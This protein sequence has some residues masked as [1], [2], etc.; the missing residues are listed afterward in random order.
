ME[1]VGL[2]IVEN[3]ETI[4]GVKNFFERLMDAQEKLVEVGSFVERVN[5]VGNDLALFLHAAEIGDVEEADDDGFDAGIAEMVLAGDFEP[6]PGAVFALDAVVV[7]DPAARSDG[8]LVDALLG[9]A[10]LIGMENAD[11]GAAD[12]FAVEI[13]EDAAETFAGVKD[14][15]V[16]GEQ[17][18]EFARRAQ[19]RGELLGGELLDA[20]GGQVGWR[21]LRHDVAAWCVG[22]SARI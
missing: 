13:A 2:A 9:G 16:A 20:D 8:E 22:P 12:E 19:Q 5:D 3:D 14:G 7:A 21:M 4:F 10:A 11:D 18:K 6:A 17:G 15:A 1:I